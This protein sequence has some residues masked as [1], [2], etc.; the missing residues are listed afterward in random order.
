MSAIPAA[1]KI[2][3]GK[4]HLARRIVELMPPRCQNPNNPAPDDLGYVHYVEPY[5]GAGAVLFANDP[6]GI[7]EVV[8][9]ID[10]ELT[11][12]W[13]VLQNSQL[14]DAFK[15]IIDAVPFSQAEFLG[16]VRA[17]N[18]IAEYPVESAV[19]FFVRCRQ[20]MAGR[21]DSF[22]PL[23]K[24]RTRRGM[25][26][27]ASAW[28][29]AVE[30]LLVV[31]ERLKR[32]LILNDDALNVIRREDGSRVLFFI[33]PPYV[34]STRQTTAEY[35]EHEMTDDKHKELLTVLGSSDFQGRF[36]LSGYHS[37]LYDDF[38]STYKWRC[39]EFQIANSA[40]SGHQKRI[41]TECCWMNY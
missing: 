37:E 3:G 16:A 26:E 21:R 1:I 24:S 28:L 34:H 6:Q 9:D 18:L 13:R 29:S 5:L 25:N 10:M 7:S 36:I 35:G 20:S 41:M 31:H 22:S 2:H 14:F 8:N 30:G 33:D 38:A 15:R 39:E 11:N 17:T 27:Q 32:V 19:N 12:F 23:T 4:S 40:A